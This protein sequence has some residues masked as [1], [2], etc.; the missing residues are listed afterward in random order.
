MQLLAAIVAVAV[1]ITILWDAF[2]TIVLPRRVRRRLRVSLVFYIFTW[3]PYRAIARRLK[4][5][6]RRETFLSIYGPLSLLGLLAFWAVGLIVG[7]AL[8]QWALGSHFITPEHQVSF[9]TVLYFSGTTF[10]TLGLGD[11]SPLG[12]MQR[13]AAV[14]EAGTGFAFLALIIGY[15]PIFYQAFSR[16]EQSV[17][18][19]DARAGSPPTASEFL[20]R[21]AEACNTGEIVTELRD[22][23]RWASELLES[24]LS[25]PSLSYFRSQHDNESWLAALTVVLDVCAL[26][27]VGIDDLPKHQARL[28]FAMARHTAVDLSQVF[29]TPVDKHKIPNRLPPQELDRLR[30]ALASANM[31]LRDDEQAPKKLK[32]L[33]ALYEPYVWTLADFLVAPLPAWCAA[34]DAVD[35]WQ[36]SPAE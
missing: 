6:G 22:W 26:I 4:D 31:R 14:I 10:F 9:G 35:D 33:R 8:L 28:T 25:Y 13:T 21:H 34:P 32:E 7:F 36:S 19:L 29:S 20:R 18:L 30:A 5:G 27:L 16:R 1:I 17:T 2:E 15:L 12:A 24:Q 11:V 3:G 23:E